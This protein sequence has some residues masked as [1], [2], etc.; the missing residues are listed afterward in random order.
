[1]VQWAS[2]RQSGLLIFM[3]GMSFCRSS[4]VDKSM[5]DENQEG[6]L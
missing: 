5:C 3:L 6:L 1:M 4:T 2:L